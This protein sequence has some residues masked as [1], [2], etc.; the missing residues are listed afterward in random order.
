MSKISFK[1]YYQSKDSL[2]LAADDAPR[3]HKL[4]EVSKYCKIPVYIDEDSVEKIYIPLKPKDKIEILW[5]YSD[6]KN[7]LVKSVKLLTDNSKIYPTWSNLKFIKWIE[8][9]CFCKD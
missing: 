5:E 1:E 2:R 3:V 7:P 6:P 4:Y 9:T 8:S